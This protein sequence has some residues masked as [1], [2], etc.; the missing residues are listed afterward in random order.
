VLGIFRTNQILISLLLVF[1]ALILRS[2]SLAQPETEA[3]AQGGI[4]YAWLTGFFPLDKGNLAW[5]ISLLLVTL[6]SLAINFLVNQF[7]LSD[8]NHL[9]GG[10]VYILIASTFKEMHFLSPILLGISFAILAIWSMFET[11]R[12][13]TVADYT[14]NIGFWIGVASLFHFPFAALLLWSFIGMISLRE[15]D[16]KSFLQIIVGFIVPF[17]L[18]WACFFWVGKGEFF[19]NKA[20]IESWQFP[21]NHF[22]MNLDWIFKIGFLIL[23]IIISIYQY[24]DLTS[25]RSIQSQKLGNVLFQYLYLSLLAFFLQVNLNGDQV[26]I[27]APAASMFLG[28]FLVRL[29]SSVAEVVHLVLFVSIMVYQWFNFIPH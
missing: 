16:L 5:T 7:R 28:I 4:L 17:F 18:C 29:P 10:L 20:L 22:E 27:L 6:H 13:S 3:M 24:L 23:L 12:R 8:E 21:P 1:Y 11:F 9:F 2:S 15:F 19:F 14:F 26:L 25:G